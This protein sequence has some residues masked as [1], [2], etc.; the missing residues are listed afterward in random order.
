MSSA[1]STSF[2]CVE[3]V[4]P[5]QYMREYV[6]AT[7]SEEDV[8]SLAVKQYIPLDNP[9]P[10]AGDVTILAAHANSLP[11]ETY[12]PLWEEIYSR[13]KASGIRIRGVWMA[14]A[15]HQGRSGVL[16]EA[17]LGNDPSWFDHPR[18]LLHLVNLKHAEMP[19][20]IVGI[21]HSMGGAHL[22]SLS[23]IHPRL[24]YSLV[25]LD[26]IIQRQ[27][28]ELDDGGRFDNKRTIRETTQLSTYRRDRWPSRQVA[29][30][31]FNHSSF[32][33]S[34]D[35][36][37]MERWVQYGLRDLPTAIH[38][39]G[40]RELKAR[41]GQGR[42]VTLTTTR[43]QEVFTFSRP[44][45]DETDQPGTRVT[46]PDVDPLLLSDF[47]FYR[48]E[49]SRIFEQLPHLRPSTL[50]VFGGRC[51]MCQ[52]EL[53]A[54]ELRMTGTGVGGSGGV[55]AGRVRQVVLP[56]FGHLLA[57]EAANECAD[58]IVDWL[59]PELQ[60]WQEENHQFRAA[61]KKKGKVERMTVDELWKKHVPPLRPTSVET[62]AKL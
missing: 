1:T 18:D 20:P 5:C 48:P 51:M 56:P 55:P 24:L 32:Y 36:R 49:L 13:W 40:K 26:P 25:L 31:A 54:D 15:A 10:H 37:A 29:A 57:Q 7:A 14:D 17:M 50:Y 59:G 22:I 28:T 44:L 58:S 60:R 23:L 38:P 46:H 12:E 11:K 45:Y 9:S 53:R 3:H 43:H 34:W 39:L 4:V 35:P 16:N 33:Q 27:V 41:G 42:P 62:S 6:A 21:G 47:P 52:P 61:W 2:R 19:Q 30:E 8:L